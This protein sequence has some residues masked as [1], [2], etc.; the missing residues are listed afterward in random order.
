ME[1]RN[2][3]DIPYRGMGPGM[4]RER[5]DFC[6]EYAALRLREAE[7]FLSR[8]ARFYL[9]EPRHGVMPGKIRSLAV[10]ASR[11]RSDFEANASLR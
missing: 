4:V 1:E 2:R 6:F 10:A 8:L 5:L 3:D 7:G 9:A 11:S